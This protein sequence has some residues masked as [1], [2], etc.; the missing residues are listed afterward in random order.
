M[1]EAAAVG[2]IGIAFDH[3]DGYLSAQHRDYPESGCG[4][5]GVAVDVARTG[6]SASASNTRQV[7]ECLVERTRSVALPSAG[8]WSRGLV[9]SMSPLTDRGYGPTVRPSDS[10]R[11]RADHSR[12]YG[13]NLASTLRTSPSL[14]LIGET[15]GLHSKEV[16][17]VSAISDRGVTL[18]VVARTLRSRS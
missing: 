14:S 16:T 2:A 18:E 12:D 15:P 8:S 10:V 4:V 3:P 5:A 1:P 9:P 6:S 7:K 11:Q 13:P 17:K